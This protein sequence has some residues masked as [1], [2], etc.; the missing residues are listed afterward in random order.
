[1]E[2]AAITAQTLLAVCGGISIVGAAIAVIA[3][4]LSPI[5]KY[6]KRMEEMQDRQERNQENNE[7]RFKKDFES[8]RAIQETDKLI[9][10]ALI[11]LL[12]HQVTGNGIDHL[13]NIKKEIETFLIAK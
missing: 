4:W 9:L 2:Q 8:I 5:R 6:M 1:M 11:I 3:K 12:D 10:K 7:K 13:K